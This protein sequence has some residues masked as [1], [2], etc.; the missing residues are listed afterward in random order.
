MLRPVFAFI[1]AAILIFHLQAHDA[2]IINGCFYHFLPSSRKNSQQLR[3]FIAIL[4]Y[5]P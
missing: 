4:L 1:Y 2:V 3:L 5:E